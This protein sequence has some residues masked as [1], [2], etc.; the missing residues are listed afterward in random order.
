MKCSCNIPLSVF[1]N[2][3]AESIF[4]LCQQNKMKK[5]FSRVSGENISAKKSKRQCRQQ[6]RMN[7]IFGR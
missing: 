6:N 1:R 4:F 3:T 2:G 5:D 7:A